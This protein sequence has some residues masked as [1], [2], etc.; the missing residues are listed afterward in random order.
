MSLFPIYFGA[1]DI[2]ISIYRVVSKINDIEKII[3]KYRIIDD[4]SCL[5]GG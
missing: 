1:S 2:N 4:I 5:L 3:D